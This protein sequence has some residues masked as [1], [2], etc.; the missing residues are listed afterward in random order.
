MVNDVGYWGICWIVVRLFKYLVIIL[1]LLLD[2]FVLGFF[3]ISG[4]FL[5]L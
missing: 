1:L 3:F 2:L 4:G 5:F